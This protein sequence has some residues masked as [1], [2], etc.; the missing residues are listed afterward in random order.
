[1]VIEDAATTEVVLVAAAVAAL[2]AVAFPAAVADSGA[3]A[4]RE[5]GD[6]TVR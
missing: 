5:D 2:A 6:G 3:V 4:P 1:M